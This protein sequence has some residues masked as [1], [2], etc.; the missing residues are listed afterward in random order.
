MKAFAGYKTIKLSDGYRRIDPFA[1][2]NVEDGK[3]ESV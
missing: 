2:N 3:K 1:K